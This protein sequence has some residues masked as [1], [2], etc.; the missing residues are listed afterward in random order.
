MRRPEP[1]DARRP[2][3]RRS[4]R[5]GRSLLLIA[6]AILFVVLT[7][8]QGIAGFYTDYLWFGT[9]GLD[10]VWSGLIVVKAGLVIGFTAVFFVLM[11]VNLIIADRVAPK[12]RALGGVDDE[13]VARYQ[14]T[15]GPHTGKV[16]IG[17]AAL[18]ALIAGTG[19]SGQ[20]QSWML[21]RNAVPFGA[22]DPQ[23]NRD[24]GFYVFELP[25]VAY[26][27]DWLFV[28]LILVLLMTAV[29]HYLNGGI[30]VQSPGQRATPAVKGH[31]SVLLALLAL[32]KT[33]DYWFRRYELVYSDRGPVDGASYTD[34]N[35]QLPA[36]NLL[37]VISLAAVVLFV[38]NIWM[39]GWVLP[40]IA[41]A[42]WGLVS[43]LVGAVYPA[44]VQKFQVEPDEAAKE[45][46]Y[47]ERN[48]EATR[49]AL[50]LD[51]VTERNFQYD[52]G[53]D[54][55]G[56]QAN[57]ETIK[58]IRLWD[59]PILKDTYKRL[60]ELRD[61]FRFNDVDVDRYEIDGQLTQVVLSARD[62]DPGGLPS[63]RQSWVNKHLQFTHGYG[64]VLSPANA[65]TS[66]GQPDFLV[67]NV[68]P[69]SQPGAP[70]ITQPEVYFGEELGG[71]AIV[72]TDQG[73][74]DYIT[75]EGTDRTS[76][77]QGDG[78]VQLSSPL[79]RAA[80]ALRL[81]EINLMISGSINDD[82]KAIFR[83][84]IRDR[85][86]AAAPFLRFDSDPYPVVV[87]GRIKWVLDA[88]TTTGRYPYGQ[89]VSS[90]VGRGDLRGGGFNYIRNSVKVVVDAYDG[91]TT[92]YVVDEDDPLI[93]SWAKAF[94][95]M[96]TSNDEVPDE[97][98]KHFRYPEDLFRV[99]AS[100]FGSYHI[101]NASDFYSRSDAWEVSQDPGSGKVQ[102]GG[103]GG[104]G[105]TATTA[106]A[107]P[108]LPTPLVTTPREK[109]MD[110][111]YLLM[112]L[113]EAEREEFLILQHFVPFS[114]NDSRKELTAFL[115]AKSD[116]ENY[117]QLEVFVM[118]RDQ[119]ID[120]PAIIASR[121]QQAPEISEQITLL[122]Q[123]GSEVLLGNLLVIPIQNSLLHVQPMYVQARNTPVPEFKFAIV[124]FGD[125]VVMRPTLKEAL[126]VIFGD[127]PETLEEGL[128]DGETPPGDDG[129]DGVT[130]SSTVLELLDQAA[131][132]FEEAQRALADG[133]LGAYQRKIREAEDLV[134]RAR[135]A[136]Q[137]DGATT[138]TTTTTSAPPNDA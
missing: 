28:A 90:N 31:L 69:E 77:Y 36:L 76:K 121:I 88:Y 3:R 6:G 46:P 120:G 128:D 129:G 131:A 51:N 35:A 60:Q 97:L 53:L 91:T 42:T 34:V 105:A 10:S 135:E 68:P 122:S 92:Y 67:R 45:R 118:P 100:A 117:G 126:S 58:N 94:P 8:L 99:Q 41:V 23:F 25:F 116:P 49:A 2:P 38:V 79:R 15:V 50:R 18:F 64:A 93:A 17:I 89:R 95:E 115:V 26:V 52:T 13:I 59:P 132:A 30:R 56:L 55:A 119:Q 78:G 5:S 9:L 39:R 82:S 1:D 22:A 136:S 106:S 29:A 33:A 83:R 24:I 72:N 21:Y 7:S 4:R 44:F 84:D 11:L 96:F 70:E 113:P 61:F 101:D 47:I 48:I 138:S 110:P 54:A 137:S 86:G 40:L 112:R 74:I 125:Q 32:V 81:R 130:V 102:T 123:S 75:T 65:V 111:Y 71:Y 127:A 37:L 107:D 19:A 43:V 12:F 20:W 85:A 63:Q 134:A 109:K 80:M 66:D 14:E 124:V 114:R 98:R 103:G 133:D 16:R 87:D 57:Q 104:S 73:E 62:L 108:G 27:I